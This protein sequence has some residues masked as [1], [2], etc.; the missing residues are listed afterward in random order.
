MPDVETVLSV[1]VPVYGEEAVIEEFYRRLSKVLEGLGPGWGSEIIFID[2]GS[3]DR[4]LGLLKGLRARDRSVK[5][6]SLA[7]NFGHQ[8]AIT[9]GLDHARGNA[10]VIIDGDLQDPPEI[11]PEMIAKWKEGHKVVY[12]VREKRKGEGIFK[13]AS[14]KV[15]YRIMRR[16]S[17]V[18]VPVDA[19]DFRLIDRGVVD[20]LNGLRERN[21]YLRG[22]VS[23]CGFDQCGLIYHR[24]RRYAGKTKFSTKLM[25]RF[26]I[27]GILSF[28]DKPLKVMSYLGFL[29]TLGSFLWGLAII[30]G[31]I[32]HPGR[33]VSG[34]TSLMIVVIFVGGMQL[35][36]LGIIGLYLGRQY[37]EM[38]K[39]PLYIIAEKMGFDAPSHDRR[40]GEDSL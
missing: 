31:K 14:A 40:G 22:L 21:R 12:G 8:F 3:H 29:I 16:F 9:A 15:F 38:K 23:W 11:I 17:D 28:S 7:R 20:V 13:Q 39:R 32:V 25:V 26:A 2:D 6:L 19:G 36:S 18:D 30:L 27:D 5:I 10:V 4:T 35:I 24:D 37:N 33:A 34:W 1:V